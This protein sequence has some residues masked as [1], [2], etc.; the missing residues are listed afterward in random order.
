MNNIFEEMKKQCLIEGLEE[1]PVGED[2]CEFYDY[3]SSCTIVIN[4]MSKVKASS[5]IYKNDILKYVEAEHMIK[6]IDSIDSEIF[7]GIY[8]IVFVLGEE[9]VNYLEE[10]YCITLLDGALGQY[11]ELNSIIVINV[12]NLLHFGSKILKEDEVFSASVLN[13]YISEE[14]IITLLH[15]LGH[16]IVSNS[17]LY[18]ILDL[19]KLIDSDMSE[20]DMVESFARE[21]YRKIQDKIMFMNHTFAEAYVKEEDDYFNDEFIEQYVSN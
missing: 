5:L 1:I 13:E 17:Y 11:N 16:A 2:R 7:T 6:I 14:I 12:R 10:S 4:D 8:E 21:Q 9:D 20:E 15:E 3:D 19:E 18:E